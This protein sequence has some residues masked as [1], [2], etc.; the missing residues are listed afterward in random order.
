MC[1]VA[2]TFAQT[3]VPVLPNL[4][5]NDYY[6]LSQQ[7]IS[8]AISSDGSTI[9]AGGYQDDGGVGATWPRLL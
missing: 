6:G 3:F 4:V 5:G 1:I 8:V 2:H 9:V 7:G